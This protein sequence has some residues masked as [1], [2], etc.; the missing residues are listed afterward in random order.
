[1]NGVIATAEH[2]LFL[3]VNVRCF[4]PFIAFFAD[5]LTCSQEE[6]VRQYLLQRSMRRSKEL[7]KISECVA[8]AFAVAGAKCVHLQPFTMA[9]QS[10]N[11]TVCHHSECKRKF[12]D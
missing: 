1:M 6:L 12:A 3:L 5:S 4:F 2:V 10:Q 9:L 7:P 8:S 11:I